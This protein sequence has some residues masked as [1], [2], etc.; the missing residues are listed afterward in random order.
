[1]QQKDWTFASVWNDCLLTYSADM[2]RPVE[3]RDYIYASELGGSMIDRYLKMLGTKPTN[4]PNNRS[5]RK[6]Q[7]GNLWE[8][9]IQYVLLRAGILKRKQIRVEATLPGCLRVSGRVDFVAGGEVDYERAMREVDQLEFLLDLLPE[10]VQYSTKKI[11]QK[12]AEDY[13]GVELLTKIMEVKSCSTFVFERALRTKKAN[14]NHQLQNFHYV[15]GSEEI[16]F[17]CV[18]YVCKDDCR[19]LDFP[20]YSTSLD[21][22][23]R[24][25]KDIHTISG[26]VMN[27]ELPPREELIIFDEDACKFNKNWKVEY[28]NYLTKLYK[29]KSPMDYADQYKGIAAGFNSTFKRCVEGKNLTDLNK[30]RIRE[31][32]KLFPLWDDYV[33]KAKSSGVLELVEDEID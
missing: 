3:P 19:L 26:Y 14:P 23:E 11:I 31:A 29:F 4:P 1:M 15:F 7:A 28:S 16:D 18:T 24:Y 8:A 33:E 13:A 32:K 10:M 21:I 25:E 9:I 2:G 6:F 20:I 22:Q 12:F 30:Q 27:K 17:G 5:L